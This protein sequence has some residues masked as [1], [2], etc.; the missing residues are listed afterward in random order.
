CELEKNLSPF[1]L[2]AYSLDLW[3]LDEFAAAHNVK[4][5]S[6]M[7]T[8]FVQAFTSELKHKKHHRDSSIRRKIAVLRAFVKFLDRRD[9][10]QGNPVA[11]IWLTFKEPKRLPVI[12]QRTEV[13]ALLNKA[14]RECHTAANAKRN[15]QALRNYA[16]LE[17]LFYSGAR[18]GEI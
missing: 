3:Q 5:P 6:Q 16:F 17:I 14:R 9:L 4:E 13:N 10:I 12:L 2:K 11:K 8:E 7:T 15:G 1:T 18:V